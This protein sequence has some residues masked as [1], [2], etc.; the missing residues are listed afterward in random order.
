MSEIGRIGVI[1]WSLLGGA[2]VAQRQPATDRAA[3]F[4]P[5]FTLEPL[6]QS[7]SGRPGDVLSFR[8]TATPRGSDTR[9]EILPVSIRQRHDG[10]MIPMFDGGDGSVEIITPTRVDATADRPV[11]I[12]GLIRIPR[13]RTVRTH[14]FGVVVRDRGVSR[15]TDTQT[16]NVAANLR[17]VTQYMARFDVTASGV[18]D[19]GARRMVISDLDVIAA[20]GR[21]MITAE[22]ENPTSA[23][24]WVELRAD[25]R[26]RG[27]RRTVGGAPDNRTVDAADPGL[28]DI[29]LSLWCNRRRE[30]D[31]ENRVRI[32]PRTTVR[33]G[34]FV[35]VA[36]PA[37]TYDA[38]TSILD[39]GRKAVDH[40]QTVNVTPEAF[41][42]QDVLI[43]TVGGVSIEPVQLALS[44]VR[45]SGPRSRDAGID[46][47]PTSR[48]LTV[49]LQNGADTE[50]DIRLA[51]LA[52][53][54]GEGSDGEGSDGEGS[55]GEG[56]D[57]GPSSTPPDLNADPK[58]I[59]VTPDA[60]TI[61]PGRRRRSTLSLRG[62]TRHA[63]HRYATLLIGIRQD[64]ASGE[65]IV[66][67]PIMIHGTT[68]PPPSAELDPPELTFDPDTQTPL[69]AAAVSNTS[70][71]HLPM[72]ARVLMRSPAG[73]VTEIQ[74]GF[75]R[76][77][78]PAHR[79]RI[80]FR[81]PAALAPGQYQCRVELQVDGSIVAS[82]RVLSYDPTPPTTRTAR[83]RQ[84]SD[85]R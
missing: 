6:T 24:R 19:E 20:D 61:P 52:G 34:G 45:P 8:M 50:A 71:T 76:W 42:A 29:P 82:E 74:G 75:S 14:S 36:V 3:A 83:R 44:N 16:R 15:T 70:S 2:V 77:L 58:R 39:D 72:V 63:A 65:R 37:G 68:P 84:R 47:P 48:R 73:V 59:R 32:L 23:T 25:L 79:D 33:I 7:F 41:P 21:P 81:P 10:Q 1:F 57:G 56:S 9:L 49:T 11:T 17:F 18:R 13:D 43:R 85:H 78:P 69:I 28:T 64:D 4:R 35:P 66:R 22:L 30:A 67:L 40:R 38:D 60:M 5:M 51:I 26:P 80:L 54:D 46:E 62:T 53:I 55:D 27:N 31:G 12:E